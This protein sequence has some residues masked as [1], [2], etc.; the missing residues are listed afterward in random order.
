MLKG[1]WVEICLQFRSLIFLCYA[2]AVHSHLLSVQKIWK[3][4]VES[5]PLIATISLPWP[6]DLQRGILLLMV[7]HCWIIL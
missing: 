4:Q 5:H 7:I 3:T 1:K 2:E 6:I